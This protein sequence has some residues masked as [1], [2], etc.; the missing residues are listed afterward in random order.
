MEADVLV[1]GG[2][3]RS[4]RRPIAEILK[5]AG[6]NPRMGGVVWVRERDE[7]RE[8]IEF[9]QPLRGPAARRG[10]TDTVQDQP[11]LRALAL[12]HLQIM[13]DFTETVLVPQSQSGKPRP[14][15]VPTLGAFAL[16]KANTFHLRGGAEAAHKAGKDLLYLRDIAAAG[17]GPTAVLEKDLAAI[18]SAGT[19]AEAL[20]RRAG[21]QLRQVAPRY[22][23]SAAEILA[24][25]EG[26]DIAGA[27][28]DVEG[29][30]TD[31][32]EL[33]STGEET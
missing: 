17:S 30:L 12:D 13:E 5:A 3:I 7:G 8:K 27:R 22:Y 19:K 14:V 24:E 23:G 28:A 26:L 6:F 15:R 11:D 33:L 20:L 2:M 4:G 16:N 32:S 18:R 21:F 1:P 29:H 9:M 10:S 25:R 31:V